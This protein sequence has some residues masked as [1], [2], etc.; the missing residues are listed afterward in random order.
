MFQTIV[1]PL[2]GSPTA[3]HVLSYLPLVVAPGA[4]VTLVGVV[5]PLLDAPWTTAREKEAAAEVG[6]ASA[7]LWQDLEAR[8]QSLR[9]RGFPAVT[10][11][12]TGDLTTEILG[13]ARAVDADR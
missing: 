2:D 8:A 6:R 3:A 4:R 13:C 5:T 7:F 11:V 9:A 10:S 1:V 12:R